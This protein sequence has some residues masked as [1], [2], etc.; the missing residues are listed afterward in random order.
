MRHRSA[1]RFAPL[2]ALAALAVA[3]A[4]AHA[5][6]LPVKATP[7]STLTG[8]NRGTM[9]ILL[10]S[11]QR[12]V[13]RVQTKLVDRKGR[14]VGSST[15]GAFTGQ[16]VVRVRL[17]KRLT[18]GT[19]TLKLSGRAAGASTTQRATRALRFSPGA[20]PGGTAPAATGLRQQTAVVDWS[21]GK[22]NGSEVAG[23]VAPGIGHGEVLCRPNAQWIRF[24][25]ND[26][27]REQTM[28][29]WTY[30]DWDTF[31]E[32]ALREAVH[33]ENTGP[34]FR[35]GINKFGPAEKHSTGFFDG[36]ITDRGVIGAAGGTTT[37]ATPTTLHMEW[38]WDFSSEG[39]ESCHVA[40]TFTSETTSTE[41]PLARSAQVLWRGDANA[42]GRDAS[43]VNVPG[44]GDVTV[45]CEA[46]TRGNRT[47]TVDTPDGAD[48]TTR[49][50]SDHP[51]V[52]Q[53]IGPVVANLPN[54]GMLSIDFANGQTLLASSR[55]KI[56]DPDGGRNFCSI[57]A[58]MVQP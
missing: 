4:G 32:F 29:N 37:L 57:A 33:N 48:V 46:G 18:A 14:R 34:D 58:Q 51:T 7:I 30:K 31:Q 28:M 39:H 54:N 27:G 3:P 53:S 21:D 55:Y 45:T 13:T 22:W 9:R 47:L 43:T 49:E 2:L 5:A 52:G 12:K 35:E 10:S 42:A 16:A 6:T 15:S 38:K 40:A 1:T 56:N 26:Q 50:G 25:P 24:Y 20:T 41:R 11:G 8:D 17:A 44:L 23:F 36:I 19:Y